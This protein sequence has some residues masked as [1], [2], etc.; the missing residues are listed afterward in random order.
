ML[1][2]VSQ[3]VAVLEERLTLTE[4]K[5]RTCLDNQVLLMQQTQQVDR[6]DEET[7]GSSV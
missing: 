3:T 7:E 6:S 1:V 2:F 5:L 4:D